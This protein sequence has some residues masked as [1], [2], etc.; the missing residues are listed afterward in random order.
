METREADDNAVQDRCAARNAPPGGRVLRR[1]HEKPGWRYAV[2]G[3]SGLRLEW[4]IP[5]RTPGKKD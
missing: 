2:Q 5:F 1:G 4:E 3:F